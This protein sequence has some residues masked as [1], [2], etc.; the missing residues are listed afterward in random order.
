M[1]P[2]RIA[3]IALSLALLGASAA[4]TPAATP[5]IPMSVTDGLALWLDAA[6]LTDLTDGAQV[7]PWTDMSGQNNHAALMGGSPKYQSNQLNGKPVVRFATPGS[8]GDSFRFPRISNIRSV[9]WVL[10]E[11]AGLTSVSFLLGGDHSIDFHRGSQNGPLWT[12]NGNPFITGGTTKLMGAV[13]DG[14]KTALPA[15]SYQL[16]SLVTTGNVQANTVTEDRGPSDHGSWQGDIA[17]IL[18]YTRELTKVEEAAVGTYL[19]VKYGLTTAYPPAP[20]ATPDGLAAVASGGLVNLRWAASS[21]AVTYHVKRSTTGGT[22]YVTLGTAAETS[23]ADPTAVLGTACSY[24]VSAVNS[25][26]ESANSPPAAATRSIKSSAKHMVSFGLPDQ[27]AVITGANIVWH[28]PPGTDVITLAPTYT[29]SPWARAVPASGTPRNCSK[30]HTCTVTA[31]DGTTQAYQVTVGP[32]PACTLVAS[33]SAWDGRQTMTVRA[34]LTN[35]DALAANGGTD[36]SYTWSVAG[37]AVIKQAD[38]GTLRLLH[39]Q[40]SGPMTVTLVL[41]NGGGPVTLTTKIVVTEPATPEAWVQRVPAAD[42][43]PVAGQF[44]ARDDTGLGTLLYNG[45][46]DRAAESVFLRLYADDKLISSE[47]QQPAADKSY[48]L[49]AKLKPGLI[50]YKVEFGT[51]NSGIDTVIETVGNL[52][53]GDAYIID[54]QSNAEATGPNNGPAIDPET[55]V[56]TWI[57]S[58]GNQYQGTTHGGWCK[59]VRTRIWGQPDYGVGQIGAWGM[60]LAKNLVENHRIPVCIINGAYGGT[61][62]LHHQP[63]PANHYDTS[64]AFYGNPYK[65]YGCLLT[66]VAAAKLTHGIR[67]IFWHQGE[68]D[69]GGGWQTYQ[70]DFVTLTAAWKQDYPN[71]QHYYMFRIWPSACAMGGTPGADQ[72]LEYQRT[73]P[74][75]YS[76]LRVMSTLGIISGSSGPRLCHFDLDGYAQ[77]AHLI[78]PLVEQDNYGLVPQQAITAPNLKRAWFISADKREIALD[79]GQAMEWKDAWKAMIY[80]DGVVAAITSGKADGNTI[81]LQLAAPC[82]A[83]TLSYLSG[84]DWDGQSGSLIRGANGIAALTWANVPLEP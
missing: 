15:A 12:S 47:R 73:L 84:K 13:V 49:T 20:P 50:H 81:T 52:V 80:L 19:P 75:L 67:G 40:G 3:S 55:P 77:I 54:G 2:N 11:N 30:P 27:P 32:S 46:L 56:S 74:S 70:Q 66:R 28:V 34:D 17:E 64:G 42:E 43:K 16:V 8:S 29:L 60:V 82:A 61:P 22:G 69:Q 18:I 59:A 23:Y 48:A 57:R 38:A 45:K 7:N 83:K 53:C 39:A 36:V 5:S 78:T 62:I 76:N 25:L 68:N 33:T 79:F 31:E 71:I 35:Q 24:V 44:Y 37:V 26:G 58:F 72:L 65:I 6:Q 4:T 63:N 1:T 9:L 14:T 21:G 10:K 51:T 41:N